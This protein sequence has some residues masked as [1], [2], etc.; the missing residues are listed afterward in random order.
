MEDEFQS[1]LC[2]LLL[3]TSIGQMYSSSNTRK[4]NEKLQRDIRFEKISIEAIRVL[5]EVEGLAA[6]GLFRGY[7][8]LEK[9]L[10]NNLKILIC[11]CEDGYNG[12]T[13][14]P[15]ECFRHMYGSIPS[16]LREVQR[17]TKLLIRELLQMKYKKYARYIRKGQTYT[18]IEI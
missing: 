7:E 6:K 16:E 14:K 15:I 13:G 1:F 9:W 12:V 3:Y 8:E 2:I 4:M 17:L 18:L 11:K 10:F 5:R